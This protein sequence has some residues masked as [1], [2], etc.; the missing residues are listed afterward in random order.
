MITL[1]SLNQMDDADFVG[2]LGDVFE[3]SPWICESVRS[4]RPF[5]DLTSLHTAMVRNVHSSSEA[6][7]LALLRAHPDL[8]GKA[9][10]AGALTE[11]SRGEQQGAGLDQLN[12]DEYERFNMLNGAYVT[13][14]GFPFII[15]VKGHTKSSILQA[16]AVRL[17][18][19]PDEERDTAIEQVAQIAWYRL[20]DLIIETK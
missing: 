11:H 17:K 18:N 9:A 12:A 10:R 19:A 1:T 15:A 3:H 13:R 8:A 20:S 6:Q 7:K 16:F 5:T 14:F 4:L 2:A